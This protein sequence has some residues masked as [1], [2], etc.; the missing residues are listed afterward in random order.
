[1]E[2]E[3]GRGWGVSACIISLNGNIAI[4][5]GAATFTSNN[6][7]SWTLG[8]VKWW[9]CQ[10][11]A[12]GNRGTSFDRERHYFHPSRICYRRDRRGD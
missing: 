4:D 12:D 5:M 7:G 10:W 8:A 1:M 6:T 3:R 2:V 11:I 9:E